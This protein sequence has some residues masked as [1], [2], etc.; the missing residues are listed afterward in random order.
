MGLLQPAR[1]P[2]RAGRRAAGGPIMRGIEDLDVGARGVL[3]RADLN[4]PLDGTSIADDGRIRASLPTITDLTRRGARGINLPPLGRPT[5][6]RARRGGRVIFGAPRAR[7]PGGSYAGRA[8]AGPSLAP[9]AARL[10]ELLGQPVQLAD[11]V[12]GEAAAG[13]GAKPQARGA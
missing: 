12:A 6:A 2:D 3:L 9:V 11:D 7:P 5:R 1:R 4:V 8:A 10:G 13:G